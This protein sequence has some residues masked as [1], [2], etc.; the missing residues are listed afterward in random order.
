[1]ASKSKQ[2]KSL[3]NKKDQRLGY[4]IIAIPV[5]AFLIKLVTMGNIQSGIW[6]GADAENYLRGTDAILK[7]GL[8]SKDG[9]LSYWPAGYPILIWVLT[10]ISLTNVLWIL[11][12]VQSIFYAYAS[13]YFTNQLQNTKLRPYLFW[14]SVLLAANPTLSLSTVVIGYEG[15]IAA[16]MLMVCGLIIKSQANPI[17]RK[18]WIRV[19][20]AGGFLALA[21]FMQ[22]RWLLTGF[23]VAVLWLLTQK[24]RKNQALIF[25]VLM[26]VM[27]LAPAALMARNSQAGNGPIV[28]T[29]LNVALAYGTGDTTSGGYQRSGDYIKCGDKEIVS[30]S[31]SSEAIIC[32]AKWYLTNPGRTLEL[33][34]NKSK[35]FWSP[36]F[37][38]EANGT[39][40]RNP[41]IKIDPLV[42]VAKQSQQGQDLVFGIV[43]KIFSWL[44]IAF[45]I[46]L[47]FAGYL[48]LRR[49]GGQERLIGTILLSPVVVSWL[50]AIIT[51]GDHRFRI[52]TMSLSLVLQLIGFITLKNLRK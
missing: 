34:W 11:A 7:D 23:V 20:A 40:A 5:I 21:A 48:G 33:T 35:F 4:W 43:G 2:S 41:W 42:N 32:A 19:A 37:G 26:T 44:F 16:C 12:F 39:M 31:K 52:P 3:Q 18:F 27:S 13:Y 46:G 45:S 30:I 49:M 29:N 6:P 10:K 28:S 22:P 50:S 47:L 8:A 1:M 9:L 36:W 15:P 51:L 14:I 24:S 38:P 25:V 17:D